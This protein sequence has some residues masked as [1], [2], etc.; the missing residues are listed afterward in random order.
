MVGA[1][2]DT[3]MEIIFMVVSVLVAAGGIWLAMR[4]YRGTMAG[5]TAWKIRL[6]SVY[7]L[8]YNKY[9]IDELY[10]MAVVTPLEAISRSFFWHGIDGNVIDMSVNGVASFFLKFSGV[11]RKLQSGV[12]QAYAVGVVVGIIVIVGWFAFFS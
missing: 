2:G 12:V 3:G 9:Y 1:P 5:A 11:A 8:L 4:L 10:S 7:A 6:R